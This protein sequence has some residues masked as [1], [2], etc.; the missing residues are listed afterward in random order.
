M[1]TIRPKKELEKQMTSNTKSF[2][3]KRD[4]IVAVNQQRDMAYLRDNI[5]ENAKNYFVIKKMTSK[6]SHKE[7]ETFSF[8]MP[9]I[10]FGAHQLTDEEKE[11]ITKYYYNR[12]P[13]VDKEGTY[14]LNEVGGHISLLVDEMIGGKIP[15]RTCE[16]STTSQ[17]V[18]L[19]YVHYR[20]M[21]L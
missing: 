18:N 10:E 15:F 3:W 5:L 14:L 6:T 9:I 13:G 8:N 7:G 1:L 16:I 2:E 11:E 4:D 12:R 20:N 19:V 21:D 17:T